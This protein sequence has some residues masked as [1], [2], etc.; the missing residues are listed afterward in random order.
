MLC[1]WEDVLWVGLGDARE[2][3]HRKDCVGGTTVV[4]VDAH[5]REERKVYLCSL[6]GCFGGV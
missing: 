3:V 6:R 5:A 1:G 4:T 2:H